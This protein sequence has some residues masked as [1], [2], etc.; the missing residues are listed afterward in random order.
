MELEKEKPVIVANDAAPR[1]RSL[2]DLFRDLAAE[3]SELLR[4]ELQRARAEL[5]QGVQQLSNAI[6]QLTIGSAVAAA[7]SLTLIASAVVLLGSVLANYWLGAL[8]VSVL[9]LAVGGTLIYLGISRLRQSE[10]A[11][12]ETMDSLRVT[13]LWASAEARELQSSLSTPDANV[14]DA[15]LAEDS[16][17]HMGRVRHAQNAEAAS[18]RP[19]HPP[20][21]HREGRRQAGSS[22]SGSSDGL[23]KRVLNQIL[24]DDLLGEA[25]K[26]AF[27]AFL[28]LP[29]AMLVTFALLGFFGGDGTAAVITNQLQ[30]ALPQ[31]ATELVERLV[32]QVVNE[33][34]PGPFSIGL[35]LALWA[36]S[37]VFMILGLS[38]T[39]TYDL[40][41]D[42]S[43]FRRRALALGVMLAAV[44][45]MF[46]ASVSLIWGPQIANSLDL[47]GAAAVA[48]NILHWPVAFFFVT[49]AFYLVYYI[50][51]DKDQSDSKGILAKAALSAAALWLLASTGFRLYV[52]NFASYSES[53]GII[54][55][56]IVLLLWLYVTALVVLIGGEAASEMEKGA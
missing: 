10:L 51:P 8:I 25:A 46:V 31:E 3:S 42:R 36:A 22:G 47:W 44:F 17:A 49:L 7:G 56:V 48:W 13:G 15:T 32:D 39:R 33:N 1:E 30:A 20:D 45:L 37:N 24:E 35:V 18:P 11:P 52:A 14:G 28:A 34:A 27:Y 29:P 50:L 41:D 54:G 5:R 6:K 16:V 23:P 2:G 4:Q 53:Y 19:G 21:R 9:L 38:L 26:V 55:A 40:E 12:R 43:W